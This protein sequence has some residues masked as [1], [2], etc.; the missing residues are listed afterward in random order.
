MPRYLVFTL[1]APLMSFGDIAPGERRGSAERPGRSM[2]L[3]L[4]AAASGL[5]RDDDRQGALA[6]SLAFSVRV[7][8]AGRALLDY[9]TTQTIARQRHRRFATRRAELA[10]KNDLT[11]ILSQR[12]YRADAAFTIAVGEVA[13]GPFSLDELAQSLRR[14]A[15]PV[16]AGRRACPLGLPPSP[17]LIEAESL[18]EAFDHYDRSEGRNAERAALRRLFLGKAS[19]MAVDRAFVDSDQLGGLEVHR[20]EN[21]RDQPVDRSRWQFAPRD[22]GIVMLSAA[23]GGS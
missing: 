18:T 22:E 17:A 9:H 8:S 4:L 19:M 15:L 13:A 21:R 7:D 16:H 6:A 11:T 20:W 23:G 3:G 1:A 12:T 5:W 2:L 10:R 14:P